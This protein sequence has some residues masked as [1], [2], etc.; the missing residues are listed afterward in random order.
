ML[1]SITFCIKAYKNNSFKLF[2]TIESIAN[3]CYFPQQIGI[4]CDEDSLVLAG[5]AINE[6]TKVVN[7]PKIFN[8][9]PLGV[10]TFCFGFGKG[11][12]KE[13]DA[14]NTII[15]QTISL[16]D[17]YVVLDSGDTIPTNFTNSILTK[18]SQASG[19]IGF[20]YSDYYL[21]GLKIYNDPY[22]KENL[23]LN[24]LGIKNFIFLRNV[25]NIAKPKDSEINFIKDI[26]NKFIGIHIPEPL[27]KKTTNE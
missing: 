8:K 10:P 11:K 12:I 22:T 2:N 4:V 21:D 6:S 26:S 9:F 19:I 7:A 1:P 14:L 5:K 3:T 24:K 17:V 15:D 23:F 25:L 20:L 16:T 18:I 13:A 27:F